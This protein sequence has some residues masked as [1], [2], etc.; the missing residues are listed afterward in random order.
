MEKKKHTLSVS[1]IC[2]RND[3]SVEVAEKALAN[4]QEKGLIFGFVPGDLNSE[5]TMADEASK[6]FN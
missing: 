2:K 4:L 3:I 6:Y 1:D 5:I